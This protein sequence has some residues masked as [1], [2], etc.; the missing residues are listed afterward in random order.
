MLI[1]R[2]VTQKIFTLHELETVVSLDDAFRAL[3]VLDFQND[4]ESEAINRSSKK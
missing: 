3:A 4:M 2:L 1:W